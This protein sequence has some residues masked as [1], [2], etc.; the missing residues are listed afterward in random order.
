MSVKRTE[1]CSCGASISLIGTSKVGVARAIATWREGHQGD[2]HGPA[3]RQQA[4]MARI[5]NDQR[6]ERQRMEVIMSMPLPDWSDEN[7]F[8]EAKDE[9]VSRAL[10]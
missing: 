8:Q 10:P 3:T 6:A 4:Y 9:T 1:Y 7:P 5:R 2:G